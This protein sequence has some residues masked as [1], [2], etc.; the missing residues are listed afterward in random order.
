MAGAK[1]PRAKAL[2]E[3]MERERAERARRR[4]FGIVGGLVALV[5]VIVVAMIVVRATRHHNPAAASA[6][7]TA[8]AG[9]VSSVPTGILDKAG[10]GGASA[11]MPISGQ[12]ALTSNGKPELLY[13]GA[14]WCP[15]CAAERWPLAVALS[16][17]GKLTGL[18]Q[19]RSAATDVYANTATLSFAKVSYT[20][21]Y[22]TFTPAEI[23]DVDRKPLTTLTAVQHNLFT[24]VGGGG[25]PFIDFGN[26]YRISTAT[27][28][29]GLLKGL[30]QAQIAGSLAKSG[31]KVGTAIAGSA[32]VITATI[33]ALTK[34]QPVSVC[35]SATI[36]TIERALGASG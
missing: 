33:C 21:K 12:Q 16:R 23:Q 20:S 2:A 36:Q 1:T 34:D 15:Y 11:P 4:Q 27:Y 9:Q 7:S 22:L 35:K 19:V 30:D 31:N 10:S 26:R 13:V 6:A 18:Q 24:T 5:V 14:E 3:Q 25:F 32:N 29:P 17:F 8:I 28:D